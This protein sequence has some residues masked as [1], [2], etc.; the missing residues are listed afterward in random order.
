MIT[1]IATSEGW[2]LNNSGF[3]WTSIITKISEHFLCIISNWLKLTW[4]FLSVG[5]Q[6]HS[7]ENSLLR[8]I[9]WTFVA[10]VWVSTTL[11][12]WHSSLI[13][14]R[15]QSSFLLWLWANFVPIYQAS[16][17]H[18]SDFWATL[19]RSGKSL[20]PFQRLSAWW[21]RY[22]WSNLWLIIV[23]YSLSLLSDLSSNLLTAELTCFSF[24]QSWQKPRITM[25]KRWRRNP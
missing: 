14:H 11:A 25:E 3:M 23:A 6:S 13:W 21:N 7:Y 5:K 9:W 8:R 10:P 20:G 16:K 24:Y 18:K 2:G 12:D 15:S 1:I 22:E 19:R 17:V 4:T